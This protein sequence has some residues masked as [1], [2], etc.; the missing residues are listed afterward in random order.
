MAR[1]SSSRTL[2]VVGLAAVA[3]GLVGL[4]LLLFFLVQ[5]GWDFGAAGLAFGVLGCLLGGVGLLLQAAKRADARGL[6]W[7]PIEPAIRTR[8]PSGC[9]RWRGGSWWCRS[10]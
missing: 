7:R 5:S 8:P 9:G 2:R 4:V 3:F 10:R 6:N 1:R